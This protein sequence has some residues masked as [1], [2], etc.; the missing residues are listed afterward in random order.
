MQSTSTSEGFSGM[1]RTAAALVGEMGR[2]GDAN[3]TFGRS[4]LGA[5]ESAGG[6]G[7]EIH[8]PAAPLIVCSRDERLPRRFLAALRRQP[9][10]PP[11]AASIRREGVFTL[12]W[13]APGADGQRTDDLMGAD[14]KNNAAGWTQH[15]NMGMAGATWEGGAYDDEQEC[16]NLAYLT[17]TWRAAACALF[18]ASATDGWDAADVQAFFR[19]R[20]AG[21]PLIP[22]VVCATAPEIKAAMTAELGRRLHHT[23]GVAPSIIAASADLDEH[24]G[25][26]ADDGYALLLRRILAYAPMA[27]GALGCEAPRL[28]RQVVAETIR[29]TAWL[30]AFVGL[31]PAPLVDLPVQLLMQRRMAHT[32]A[33]I[34]GQPQ[35][36]LLNSEGVGLLTT[37]L[38]LRYAT[39][40]LVRLAPGIG[41][42]LS[43]VLSGMS[44]WL[45]GRTLVLHYSQ[46]LPA[47]AVVKQAV[48]VCRQRSVDV[49][50]WAMTRSRT[51][52]FSRK[53]RRRSSDGRSVEIPIAGVEE[54][55]PTGGAS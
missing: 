4:G 18:L 14:S 26:V 45:L 53:W 9:L 12:V 5:W 7:G 50:R 47:E 51:F 35:P 27:A 21:P 28:R 13:L 55:D 15:C 39:Q 43:G 32:I 48:A 16:D 42:L 23:L 41:W 3:A 20:N 34:Y 29:T 6:F 33:A 40:Q 10:L 2:I 17:P 38:T 25:D 30:T 54:V 1:A 24:A 11:G 52:R 46:A 8:E 31:E 22:V 44:T 49:V 19:L 36:G 37:G